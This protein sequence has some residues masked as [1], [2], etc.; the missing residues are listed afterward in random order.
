M[1]LLLLLLLLLLFQDVL[2]HWLDL[3]NS[4][5]WIPREQ[6]LGQ[7]ARSKV[8]NE[9]VIQHNT[10][11]NPPTLFLTFESLLNKMEEEES[12]VCL[13]VCVSWTGKLLKVHQQVSMC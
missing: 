4:D 13:Y 5:G 3:L 6:I 8:P 11:A 12:M 9:F 1:L 7:E 2:G 10:N